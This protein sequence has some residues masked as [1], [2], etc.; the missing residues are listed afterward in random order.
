MASNRK[1]ESANTTRTVEPATPSVTP[2]VSTASG[3][4]AMAP[5][6]TVPHIIA[7]RVPFELVTTDGLLKFGFGLEND[8]QRTDVMWTISFRLSERSYPLA[9]F[10]P[11]VT[12][13][14]QIDES[15]DGDAERAAKHGLT[16]TQ[17][18]HA[19]G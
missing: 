12:L 6:R 15:F 4:A 10:T 16:P 19:L 13:D 8:T 7:I 2:A 3:G 1:R 18:A 5:A 11:V 17:A 14:V 9:V